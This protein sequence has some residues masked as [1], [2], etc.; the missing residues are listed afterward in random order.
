MPATGSSSPVWSP[1]PSVQE[2]TTHVLVSV[3]PL[4]RTWSGD[5]VTSIAPAPTSASTPI[6]R[7]ESRAA[8]EASSLLSSISG[9]HEYDEGSSSPVTV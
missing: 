8:G 6:Q 4:Q 5:S 9:C 1:S 3:D 7:P 2:L